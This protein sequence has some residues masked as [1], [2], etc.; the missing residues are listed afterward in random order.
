VSIAERE[1]SADAVKSIA[2]F[3]HPIAGTHE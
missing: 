2:A 3:E 1:I